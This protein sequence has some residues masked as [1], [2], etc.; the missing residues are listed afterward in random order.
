[1]DSIEAGPR[2]TD[3]AT[4]R[5]EA[6]ARLTATT[7]L[8]LLVLFVI[9]IVTVAL[10]PRNVLTLHIVVGL[11]LIPPVVVKL[12]STVWRMISYYRGVPEY[13]RKGPPPWWL[14][15]LGPVL[16]VLTILVLASGVLLIFGPHP[17]YGAA[18]FIHK[19][20]FYLWLAAIALHVAAHILNAVRWAYRDTARRLRVSTPGTRQRLAIVFGCVVIGTALGLALAGRAPTYLHHYPLK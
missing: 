18:L 11:M 7:G 3:E 14:R 10:Q 6:N 17:V 5:V 15:V 9:E 13:R 4:A 8:V 19:K 2:P 16:G 1:M 20:I 12:G